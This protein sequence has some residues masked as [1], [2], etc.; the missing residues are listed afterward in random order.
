M[1]TVKQGGSTVSKK[2]EPTVE[3]ATDLAA[4]QGKQA[5]DLVH[6]ANKVRGI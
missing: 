4:N 1:Q 3:E 6:K 5:S 2:A